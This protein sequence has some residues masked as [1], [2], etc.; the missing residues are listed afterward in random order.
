MF[1]HHDWVGSTRRGNPEETE[2]ID[3]TTEDDE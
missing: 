3:L 1:E 2:V